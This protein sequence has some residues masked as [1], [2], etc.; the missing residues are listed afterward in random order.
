MPL[1]VFRWVPPCRLPTGRRNSPRL[2]FLAERTQSQSHIQVTRT[3]RSPSA[4]LLKPCSWSA[5]PFPSQ[6]HPAVRS[7]KGRMSRSQR[8]SPR[9]KGRSCIDGYRPIHIQRRERRVGR[10]CFNERSKWTSEHLD[11]VAGRRFGP[12]RSYLQRRQQLYEFDIQRNHRNRDSSSHV[13]DFCESNHGTGDIP[14][15]IGIDDADV[16]IAE[17]VHEQWSCNGYSYVYGASV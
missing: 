3:S 15:S 7:R 12:D 9:R 4:V 14:G 8:R 10:W 6:R 11:D 5:R 13:Y 17:R 1:T 16:Y 2:R